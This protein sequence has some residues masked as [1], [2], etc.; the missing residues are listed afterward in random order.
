MR[1]ERRIWSR[2]VGKRSG[3]IEWVNWVLGAVGRLERVSPLDCEELWFGGREDGKAFEINIWRCGS[4]ESE[5][6]TAQV[7]L[8]GL[9]TRVTVMMAIVYLGLWSVLPF[10]TKTGS[11]LRL[12]RL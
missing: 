5:T 1:R 10:A 4:R 12:A 11:V 6:P 2:R 3:A 9:W 8:L 7:Q